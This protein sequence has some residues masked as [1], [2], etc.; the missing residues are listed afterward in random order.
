MENQNLLPPKGKYYAKSLFVK[1]KYPYSKNKKSNFP[2]AIEFKT[3]ESERYCVWDLNVFRPDLRD[4][5]NLL[6]EM[7]SK[8][9]A[10][11]TVLYEFLNLKENNIQHKTLDTFFQDLKL[12]EI[13]IQIPR[14]ILWEN[15]GTIFNFTNVR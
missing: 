12:K 5:E 11:V 7:K 2:F 3:P 1:V 15:N 13:K 10:N 6:A 9:G 8:K 14:Y 4:Q